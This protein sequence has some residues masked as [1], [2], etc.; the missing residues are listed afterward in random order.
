MPL[1][2]VL[3]TQV[4]CAE[5]LVAPDAARVDQDD[6][7]LVEFP[8]GISEKVPAVGFMLSHVH[9]LRVYCHGAAAQSFPHLVIASVLPLHDLIV[10][11]AVERIDVSQLQHAAINRRYSPVIAQKQGHHPLGLQVHVR[12]DVGGWAAICVQLCG[13]VV[14]AEDQVHI[15]A[16]FLGHLAIGC[17]RL[18]GERKDNLAIFFVPEM[19]SLT[20]CRLDRVNVLDA[21]HILEHRFSHIVRSAE[22]AEFQLPF[23]F[24]LGETRQ[25]WHFSDEPFLGAVEQFAGLCIYEIRVQ[26]LELGLLNAFQQH[27]HSKVE[28]VIAD[29]GRV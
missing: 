5:Y 23:F 21:V 20:A 27:V 13:M 7:G 24:V 22:H 18:V 19:C 14:P 29:R 10:D 16:K 26:P 15:I 17:P 6:V 25:P 8:N 12:L 28:L 2:D 3:F 11:A 1:C 4:P 9:F